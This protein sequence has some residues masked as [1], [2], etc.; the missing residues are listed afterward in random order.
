MKTAQLVC[1]FVAAP[2]SSSI[3]VR[4]T[5]YDHIPLGYFN[6]AAVSAWNN[7]AWIKTKVC[8]AIDQ[9]LMILA[10]RSVPVRFVHSTDVLRLEAIKH[11]KPRRWP[12]DD[13]EHPYATGQ[14][15]WRKN[16]YARINYAPK[17]AECTVRTFRNGPGGWCRC[18]KGFPIYLTL[19]GWLPDCLSTMMRAPKSRQHNFVKKCFLLV[20]SSS[21]LLVDHKLDRWELELVL[22]LVLERAAS[23]LAGLV[24]FL[25]REF[26][27]CRT[28][29]L[30]PVRPSSVYGDFHLTSKR[31]NTTTLGCCRI[32]VVFGKGPVCSS[33]P[34]LLS[35]PKRA[36][37]AIGMIISV[38]MA[39]K[40]EYCPNFTFF[41]RSPFRSPQNDL[42]GDISFRTVVQCGR[43]C[44]CCCCCCCTR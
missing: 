6:R 19:A 12:V 32:V 28:R 22:E 8:H 23:P 3:I 16:T 10:A 43:N 36:F 44:R 42:W 18:N 27:R 14:T 37:S 5:K 41:A 40:G 29:A 34:P 33:S 35:R 2:S 15:G 39:C 20:R 31:F 1:C 4:R 17:R 38:L 24:F 30:D 9:T 11:I 21:Q 7:C 26:S 13:S 25:A